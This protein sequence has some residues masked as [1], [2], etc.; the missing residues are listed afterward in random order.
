MKNKK[1]IILYFLS[2]INTSAMCEEFSEIITFFFRP[3]PVAQ[4]DKAEVQKRAE[5]LS[6]ADKLTKY[7]LTEVGKN[8]CTS[9]IFCSYDGYLATSDLNGQVILPRKQKDRFLTI[10]VTKSVAPIVMLEN[11][12]HHWEV[13]NRDVAK[14]Y[15]LERKYDKAARI[16]YWT[17]KEIEIPKDNIIPKQCIIIFSHPKYIYLPEGITISSE[18][19]QLI[20]PNIYVRKNIENTTNSIYVLN[21]KNFF[22]PIK[23]VYGK[24]EKLMYSSNIKD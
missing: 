22:A 16:D 15:E 2:I 21:I 4:E 8:N 12:I 1:I 23:K 18:G 11:T 20:L 3:I 24:K 5:K 19:P 14:M 17:T 9:G 13:S 7:T 10:L 6:H